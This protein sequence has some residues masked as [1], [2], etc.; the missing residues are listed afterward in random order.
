M[1]LLGKSLNTFLSR[2]KK[3]LEGVEEVGLLG[4]EED[5]LLSEDCVHDLVSDVLG[6]HV[7]RALRV[8]ASLSLPIPLRN[9]VHESCGD[10]G[11]ADSRELDALLP[12][13]SHLILQGFLEADSA[14]LGGAV[15]HQL[16]GPDDAC[17]GGH[18]HEV[19]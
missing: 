19:T 1:T 2:E 6:V 15:I 13:G 3:P 14:E 9:V 17:H 12:Q 10:E 8:S 18:R 7:L 16:R 4:E 5:P 11:G